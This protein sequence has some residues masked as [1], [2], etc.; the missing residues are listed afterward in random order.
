MQKVT[1]T[2]AILVSNYIKGDES[3]LEVLITRHKQRI[4]SFIYSKVF[5]RDIAEDIFQDTFIKVIRTLKRGKYNEEGK[6][7]PWVMRIAHNLVIDHFRKNNRMPKFD[8]SG[9]FDIF[10]VISDTSLNAEKVMVK[11]QVESDVRRLIDELPEDQ[12]EVLVMR[13]YNDMSF[14]EI[15]ER[16]GVSINTALGRMRYALINMRKVIEKHNIVLT[17]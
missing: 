1:I 8:N 5:D 9:D 10:S 15:S 11:E 7:L 2:D 4:Y 16:T 12:K 6:F 13:M 3:A 14:K 17:N